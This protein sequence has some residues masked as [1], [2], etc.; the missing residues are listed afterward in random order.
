[1]GRGR[2]IGQSGGHL[3]LPW[4]LPED[5][6]HFKRSTKGHALI[7][8]RVTHETIGR[9]LPGRL[10]LVL[11]RDQNWNAPGVVACPSLDA[12]IAMAR[13]WETAQ[14]IERAQ[15]V[16][17][18]PFIIGGAQIYEAA[19][20]LVTDLF[21]TEVDRDVEADAFFPDFDEQD[22]QEESRREGETPGLLFRHLR[23]R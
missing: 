7:M 14:Y 4:H 13:R 12:A 5:L 22:F 11:T 9:A 10:N 20:P 15:G 21:L 19:L 3:G 23:R 6:R 16:E 8:G 2:A 17:V 18:M 1:M